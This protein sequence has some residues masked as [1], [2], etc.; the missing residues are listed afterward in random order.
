MDFIGIVLFIS[1]FLNFVFIVFILFFEQTDSARRFSWL[2]AITF[3]PIAG[4]V[5]YMFFS[6][7]FL[8]RY[9]RLE[10]SIKHTDAVF[11][12]F[13]KQLAEDA[14][15]R[16]KSDDPYLNRHAP[17]I[18][19]NKNYARATLAFS[20]TVHIFT[21]GEENYKSLFAEIEAARV[22][23][24]LS[25][26][27]IRND[28]TG[29]ALISLLA[30]KAA[31]GV[32]VRL[33]YDHIGSF[34][35]SGVLFIPLKKAGGEVHKFFPVTLIAPYALNYRNH[36]KIVVIDHT[37]GYFGGINIGDEYANCSPKQRFVWRDTHIRV[38]DSAALLLEKCFLTDWYSSKYKTKQKIQEEKTENRRPVEKPGNIPLPRISC[39]DVPLQLV[40]SG[41]NDI[42]NDEIR[43]A[44]IF[45]ISTAKKSV[46]IESP[47]FT[48]DPA[49]LSILK[50]AA[51][52]GLDVKIIVPRDWD[53]F[54]VKLAA[55]PYIS[56]LTK[57]G[58]QFYHYKG[59]I[60][61]KMFVI[62]GEIAS[63][64]STN[65]DTRSF[66]LHFEL[67]AFFY[68]KEFGKTAEGI[69]IRDLENSIPA[70]PDAF[71]K[72]PVF[73]KALCNF[74]KLFAPLM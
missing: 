27:I 17:L 6:G 45:L 43:D 10:Q 9:K 24:Y 54:Y 53:K 67:N 18:K 65:V 58:I 25:Y 39:R 13:E 55:M 66:S 23:I 62:D 14:H 30:K 20:D 37:V 4:I 72:M 36:R 49:F 8:L 41:P 68:S 33:L 29:K 51:L 48:P 71:T 50:I 1:Y 7:N 11:S 28:K 2:I 47:Y 38:T 32:E 19:L 69:F 70:D 16:I 64:G 74:F 73:K 42:K 59:F 15:R 40:T 61:S 35:T 26:F 3:I 46:H 12:P 31:A 5:L 34:F 57:N 44:L 52:S 22:S 56:D 60:H 63:I 21:S